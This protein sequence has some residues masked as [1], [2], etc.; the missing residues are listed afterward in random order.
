VAD[1][2]NAIVIL[3]SNLGAAS[4]QQAPFGLVQG[5]RGRNTRN[6]FVEEVRSFFRPELFN[7]IDRVVPFAPLGEEVVLQIARRELELVRRRD[8]V[9]LRGAEVRVSEA[10]VRWLARRGFD[11]R[12]GARPLKRAIERELLV[13]LADSVNRYAEDAALLADVDVENEADAKLR[14]T[15]RAAVGEGGRQVLA[16]ASGATFAAPARDALSLRR[17]VQRLHRSA[18]AIALQNERYALRRLQESIRARREATEKAKRQWPDKPVPRSLLVRPHE[19]T[20]LARLTRVAPVH[21][22]ME[23][24]AARATALEDEALLAVYE[25]S[26]EGDTVATDVHNR[27]S[28]A[29]QEWDRLL[30]SLY[31]LKYAEPDEAVVVVYGERT[32]TLFELADVYRAAAVARGG[33]VAVYQLLRPGSADP[34]RKLV[35]KPEPFF[36]EP[37]GGTAGIALLVTGPN[38]LPL[39]ELERGVHEFL[40]D[41]QTIARCLV[42]T[43]GGTVAAYAIRSGLPLR[44]Q[45]EKSA[46][47]RSYDFDQ[48]FVDDT[49]P[50]VCLKRAVEG[51]AAPGLQPGEKVA[52]SKTSRVQSPAKRRTYWTGRQWPALVGKLI[53]QTLRE[54]AQSLVDE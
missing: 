26:P 1:F 27:L 4:F 49:T 53:D 50:E 48:S 29:R 33:R 41:K 21:A 47:R 3:T 9:R 35:E 6:H 28:A 42:E 22:A 44:E 46:V 54:A 23:A 30:L 11:A 31:V 37:P 45:I 15:V 25:P 20:R 36:A 32:E 40:R 16:A 14:V 18:A 43:G 13:P 17:D 24:V 2:S 19:E 39:F 8:G 7:R 51:P 52:T 10:A 38:A 34:D 5:E 12:Y